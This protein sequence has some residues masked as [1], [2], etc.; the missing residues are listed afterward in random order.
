MDIVHYRRSEALAQQLMPSWRHAQA[1]RPHKFVAVGFP[2]QIDSTADLVPLIDGMHE[3]RFEAFQREMGG[4]NDADLEILGVAFEDYVDFFAQNFGAT[5]C[6]LPISSMLAYYL[7]FTKLRGWNPEFGDMLEIG[8]GCGFLSF[9]LRHHQS[10]RRYAQ[11]EVTES[12]YLLQ[13]LVN[14]HCFGRR[15]VERASLDATQLRPV[16]LPKPIVPGGTRA[17][18]SIPDTAVCEHWPWWRILEVSTQQFDIVTSNANL[19]EMS[20]Q[21]LRHYVE[22]IAAVLRP[23]GAVI[24]QDLGHSGLDH[25]TIF[26]TFAAAGIVPLVFAGERTIPG[27]TLALPTFVLVNRERAREWSDD[28]PWNTARYPADD[29]V[30]RRMFEIDPI[31]RGIRSGKDIERIVQARLRVSQT[32][33][34]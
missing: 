34:A 33:S 18:I 16:I 3:G 14:R 7:V 27:R 11:I 32:P 4:L 13:H 23:T 9:F 17:S 31:N 15:F 22:I 1:H 20:L 10:L 19:A 28:Q 29:P 24:V 12:Y 30:V 25:K 21:A 6:E 5:T 8:P 26:D 2:I